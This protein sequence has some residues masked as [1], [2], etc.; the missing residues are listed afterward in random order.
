MQG[1][2]KFAPVSVA[3]GDKAPPEGTGIL[4]FT[5]LNMHFHNIGTVAGTIKYTSLSSLALWGCLPAVNAVLC[6]VSDTL[7]LQSFGP[8]SLLALFRARGKSPGWDL[9]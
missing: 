9:Q 8:A 4:Q 5:F 3:E 2:I 6:F 7:D 1:E